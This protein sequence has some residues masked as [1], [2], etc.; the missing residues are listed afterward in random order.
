MQLLKDYLPQ[1]RQCV[2]GFCINI[3]TDTHAEHSHLLYSHAI[4][5]QK[6]KF[7]E[8]LALEKDDEAHTKAS[9]LVEY[10][11]T[12][13]IPFMFLF[14]ELVTVAR[15]LLGELVE[16][17]RYNDLEAI[18]AF[19]SRHEERIVKL[20]FA[21]YLDQLEA[22]NL[23]RLSHIQ[24]M[25][26]KRLMEHYEHHIIWMLSLITYIRKLPQT[27]T[28][29]ELRHT[30]CGF[31]A[32]LHN[33]TIPYLINTS[34]FKE[35]ERLHINLHDL[36]ENLVTY[37]SIQPCQPTTM[38]HLLQK[39]DYISLEIGNEISI[40]NEIEENSKD[41]L[42]ELLTRR[43][44]DKVIRN[45]LSIAKATGKCFSLIMCDLD[46]FKDINDTYGHLAGDIVLQNFSLILHKILRK[47][48]YI[49]RFGGEEFV[50]IIPSANE[51]EARMVGEKICNATADETVTF[52]G[53]D[54]HY[55][56]S[57]GVAPIQLKSGESIDSELI[58]H[59]L[60]QADAKLYLAKKRG[61][62][63]VE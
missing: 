63:R 1:I 16:Q 51:D 24:T 41:P 35:V 48:D 17:K 4:S 58:N 27:T 5:E 54:I 23:L 22:K 8:L 36:A 37:C 10:T 53:M 52:E 57:I 25:N 40:L 32:W 11:I 39:I 6:K 3:N 9:D 61:R 38:I 21:R 43:L 42:T 44:F 60:A 7:L 56:V 26:D 49:F 20:Y 46:R 14:G 15:K 59:Y 33:T 12:H 55:T 2:E 18:N 62:N 45:Q 19:F 30:L 29:P 47:S 13:E 31:G 50:V 34:H 28:P